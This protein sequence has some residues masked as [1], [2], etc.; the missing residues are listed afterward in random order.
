M[1]LESL[2]RQS[3]IA[4]YHRDRREYLV[5]AFARRKND[6]SHFLGWPSE[7]GHGHYD[8]PLS[9][10][11]RRLERENPWRGKRLSAGKKSCIN[12]AF[13]QAFESIY[14]LSFPKGNYKVV[15]SGVPWFAQP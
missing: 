11:D 10:R 4:P 2:D 15:D 8:A 9:V 7:E 6:A 1:G 12:V 13:V 3:A 14:D 5:V